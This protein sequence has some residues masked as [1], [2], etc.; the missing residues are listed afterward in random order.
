M[1]TY[2]ET[3][4]TRSIAGTWATVEMLPGSGGLSILSTE[5]FTSADV[6]SLPLWKRMPFF[7]VQR[8]RSL[9]RTSNFSAIAG[10]TFRFLS[11]STSESYANSFAQWFAV[12]I[13]PNG[14]TCAGS[15]SS[16]QTIRPPRFGCA[17]SRRLGAA[18][19]TDAPPAR[20]PAATTPAPT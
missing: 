1:N 11:H 20:A 10:L 13:P 7:R 3:T 15:D 5:Y 12:R 16:P 8:I 2:F 19:A 14:A 9:S 4:W 17:P 6:T 18:F